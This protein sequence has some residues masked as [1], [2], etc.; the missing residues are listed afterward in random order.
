MAVSDIIK[1]GYG[2]VYRLVTRGFTARVPS[3]GVYVVAD[4]L[5]CR[6]RTSDALDVIYHLRETVE[7]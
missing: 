7:S 6:Y 3:A 1:R 2:N 5:E 4:D